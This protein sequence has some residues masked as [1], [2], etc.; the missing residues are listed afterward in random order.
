MGTDISSGIRN[1][2]QL[3]DKPGNQ[4]VAADLILAFLLALFLLSTA[5]T[6][7]LFFKPLF[8]LDIRLFDLE[9]AAGL[10]ADQIRKNYDLLISYFAF[11]NREPLTLPDFSMSGG[12]RI[13][14]EDCK[15][16]FILVQYLWISSG[17]ILTVLLLL[18]RRI[19]GEKRQPDGKGDEGK[20]RNKKTRLFSSR[21]LMISGLL[22]TGVPALIGLAALTDWERLFVS[23]HKLFFS[24][25]YWLFDP[26]TD[27]VILILPDGF[28]FQC[29]AVIL[30]L[31]IGS[32]LICIARAIKIRKA[33][34][35]G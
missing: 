22:L 8:Y 5:I 21:T 11:W 16:I 30:V 17:V 14:F 24:N 9:E 4:N 10:S 29:L 33:D 2:Y 15:K 7:V 31:V 35:Y 23:F 6:F 18:K 25:D 13:H 20:N 32:G 34:K 26:A 28:F 27:P 19:T 1:K 12:G 3:T